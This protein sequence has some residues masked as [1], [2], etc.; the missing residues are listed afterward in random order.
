MVQR[1]R[2]VLATPGFAGVFLLGQLLKLPTVAAPVV[3]TLHVTLGLGGGFGAAGTVVA[4]WTLGVAAGAQLQGRSMD[5]WGVRPVF[6][7]ALVVQ[8]AFWALVPELPLPALAAA[9]VVGGLF[10]VPGG[11]MTRVAIG[12]LVPEE[13]SHAAFSLDSVLTNLCALLGPAGGIVVAT[14]AGTVAAVLSLGAVVVLGC[15]AFAFLGSGFGRPAAQRGPMGSL[16]R[17]DLVMIFVC[18]GATG[19]MMSG[20]DLAM[21]ATLRSVDQV[22]LAAAV[23]AV[24]VASSVAGGLVSGA[25]DWSAPPAALVALLGLFMI[26]IGFVADWRWMIVAFVPAALLVAPTFAA[27]AVALGKLSEPGARATVMSMYGAAMMIGSALGAPLAG[28]VFEHG[29]GFAAFAAVGAVG[30]VAGAVGLRGLA[31]SA[32]RAVPAQTNG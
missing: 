28:A 19:A 8:V 7:A 31:R 32:P 12:G 20:S 1:Y 9:V 13:D 4:L 22:A 3:L 21:I 14:A 30:I 18:V 10:L 2:R 16:W 17:R 26:P 24:C 25:R 15:V 23:M 11:T 29:A 27:S 5:R 6:G